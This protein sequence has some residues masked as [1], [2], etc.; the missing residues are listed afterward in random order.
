MLNFVQIDN[1]PGM[2]RDVS[3]HAVISNDPQKMNEYNARKAIAESRA[4]EL[5]K[6]QQEIDELKNGM[7][8]IKSMLSA[9]LQR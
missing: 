6:H 7:K 9:L 4:S 1:E 2:I 3:N 5:I 8:E